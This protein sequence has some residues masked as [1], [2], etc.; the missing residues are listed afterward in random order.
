MKRSGKSMF[1]ALMLA[2]ILLLSLLFQQAAMASD[3]ILTLTFVGDISIGDAIQYREAKSGYHEVIREKGLE[4]PFS[5][6]ADVLS[7]DD[8]TIANLEGTMTR[9]RRHKDIRYPLVIDPAHTQILL[10]GGIDAVN[11]ANN[12]AMD[13]FAKGYRDT[14]AALDDAGIAHFG[15]INPGASS[16]FDRQLIAEVKG[17][18]VGFIGLTYPQE[19][20]VKFIEASAA[21]LR[22]KGCSLI[23]LSL[24]WGRETHMKPNA[25]QYAFA[26]KALA[27]DI[28]LIFGHHPHVIQPIAL[29]QGKPVFFSTG[30]FTFGT[31]SN[32]DPSTGMFQA[33]Y[34]L[35]GETPRLSALRVL[36]CVTGKKG[37]YRLIPVTDEARRRNIFSKL[38]LH[39]PSHGFEALPESFLLT[40]EAAF[41]D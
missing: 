30:N 5:L 6:V 13:F 29:Y 18:K 28:D 24:H 11:T 12:H 2:G 32:V 4:W 35:S 9:S 41:D 3:D 14:L 34:D 17:I 1:K 22:E 23:I 27:L 10:S 26:R 38:Y 37:D 39:K 25:A 8:L 40:G 19:S 7:A 16:G 31:M 33:V 36:P 15:T 21:A 20:D